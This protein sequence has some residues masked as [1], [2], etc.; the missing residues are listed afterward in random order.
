MVFDE[1]YKRNRVLELLGGSG[2][3]VSQVY[4]GAITEYD[5][6]KD[7]IPQL[8]YPNAQYLAER[9]VTLSTSAF[10]TRRELEEV[11]ISIKTG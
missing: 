11:V 10:L 1:P 7:F 6:P 8:S 5:Y 9:E 3:G 2:L 4:I